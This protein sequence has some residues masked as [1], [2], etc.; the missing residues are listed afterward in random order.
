VRLGQVGTPLCRTIR[1]LTSKPGIGAGVA[2]AFA[3]AGCRRIAITDL[4]EKLLNDT[5]MAISTSHPSIQLH[6]VAGDISD[7]KFVNAFIDEVMYKFGRL[8][9]AVNCAGILGNNQASV[10]TS[11]EDFDKI[12]N[13]NYRGLWL[14][15]RA[16]IR[17]MLKQDSLESHDGDDI[18][19][20]RGSVV[21]IAS[22][23]GIVGRPA[24]RE[25]H[26]PTPSN[27][28]NILRPK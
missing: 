12:N 20:Q 5:L 16:E 7:E 8:D 4:N 25:S 6:A 10:E 24:A 9:Y 23:L 18:R 15:S 28:R 11:V 17:A 13:V 3:S 26:L 22:Q 14:C 19:G 21:N 2:K 1:R 27:S